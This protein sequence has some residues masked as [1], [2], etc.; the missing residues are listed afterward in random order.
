[1]RIVGLAIVACLL[2]ALKPNAYSADLDPD[3]L[4]IEAGYGRI[5]LPGAQVDLNATVTNGPG[6]RV[7]WRQVRGTAAAVRSPN[8]LQTTVSVPVDVSSAETLLFEV[9]AEMGSGQQASD[10]VWIEVYVPEQNPADLTLVADFSPKVG[11]ECKE[12]PVEVP[13]VKV[14]VL[15]NTIEYTTNGIPA[16][17]TG[18]FP[19]GEI[20]T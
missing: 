4:S 19:T 8:A 6:A 5:V 1:M 9:R 18:Q 3:T 7:V 20:R 2:C 15:E 17:A 10:M 14:R 16:H 11:W 12:D 13:E